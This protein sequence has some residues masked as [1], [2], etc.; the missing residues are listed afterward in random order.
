MEASADISY[1]LIK[2]NEAELLFTEVLNCDRPGLYLDR[3]RR[4]S[5]SEASFISA[6]LR[7]RAQGEPLQYILG[8]AEFMGLN[9]SVNPSV[10]IPR[11]ETEILVE[12]A[13]EIITSRRSEAKN[14]RILDIGTGSGNIAISLAK[15]L[16]GITVTATDISQE[17]I[18]TA[19]GNALLH[20]VSDRVNFICS[21]LFTNYE[22]RFT[23][24][25]MIV[26]NPPY[27]VRSQ[28]A[29]LQPEVR[30]EPAVAL[31]AG[32]DGLY[33]YNRIIKQAGPYLKAGGFLLFEFGL[34]QAADIRK[35]LA[36][37]SGLNLL[38]I[39][40]DYNNIERVAIIQRG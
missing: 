38:R 37:S 29:N 40:K 12:Q 14:Q 22:L 1:A 10:L 17:A 39:V 4:L 18:Q 21:D 27:V 33:F 23:D 2:M 35:I 31:E 25:D 11:P 6:V 9:F 24:Y 26:S 32:K 15:L 36:S 34:G 13:I 19:R 8:K 16:P 20:G 7:R 30:H 5:K 3:D 28:L